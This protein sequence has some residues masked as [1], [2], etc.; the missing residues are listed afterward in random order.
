MA[1]PRKGGSGCAGP[2]RGGAG[3]SG[4]PGQ[5]RAWLGRGL[6]AESVDSSPLQRR[7]PCRTAEPSPDLA[8]FGAATIIPSN[9]PGLTRDPAIQA[10]L[11]GIV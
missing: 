8:Q 5:A 11:L 1:T 10:A 4:N 7:Y 9:R 6:E 3:R 2:G